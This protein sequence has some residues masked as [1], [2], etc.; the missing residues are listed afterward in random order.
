MKGIL[1]EEILSR[2]KM[3]FPVP[4]GNWFRTKYR[5]V[6]EEYVLSERALSRGIFERNFVRELVA[7]HN[8][9]ENHDERIWFLV[10]F[11]MWQR[12]FLDGEMVKGESAL[13]NELV[14]V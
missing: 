3:G 11:E 8:A 14:A 13:Q 4:V 1:P 12:R 2:K 7:K 6:V 9:G 10:N 5:N